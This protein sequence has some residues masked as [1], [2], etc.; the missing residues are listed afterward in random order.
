MEQFLDIRQPVVLEPAAGD[1]DR[2][3][4][5]R[6]RLHVAEVEEAV[7]R[8]VRVK[9]RV[10][11]SGLLEAAHGTGAASERPDRRQPLHRISKESPVADDP[12]PAGTLRH[13]Q[14]AFGREGHRERTH[15]AVG[16]LLH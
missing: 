13:E 5:I 1:G 3:E 10:A 12:E 7:R 11:Q 2:A 4:R 8:E 16:H 9:D 6:P 14:V 15:Q